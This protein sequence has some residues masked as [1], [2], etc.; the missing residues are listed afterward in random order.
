MMKKEDVKAR[1]DVALGDGALSALV[2]GVKSGGMPLN[3]EGT[4]I[5]WT[6]WLTLRFMI[7]DEQIK[8]NQ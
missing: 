3:D 8:S 6:E 7:A 5:S 1:L 2:D 4:V